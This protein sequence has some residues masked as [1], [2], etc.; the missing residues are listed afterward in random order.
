MRS[1][2][3]EVICLQLCF[4]VLY[5]HYKITIPPISLLIS[6]RDQSYLYE[7]TS[8]GQSIGITLLRLY[9]NQ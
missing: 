4:S 1:T 9:A 5:T 2:H 3:D 6:T 8:E 7:I